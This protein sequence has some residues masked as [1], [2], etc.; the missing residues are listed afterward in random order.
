[1]G[2]YDFILNELFSEK[3][4]EYKSFLDYCDALQNTHLFIPYKNIV[5]ICDNPTEIKL[6]DRGQLHSFDGPAMTYADGYSLF[7]SN[8][9][10]V[11]K[12]WCQTKVKKVTKEMILKET[13]VDIRRETI[14]KVGMEAVSKILDSKVIDEKLG[15]KVITFD[16]GDGRVRPYL[17]MKNPSLKGVVHIEGLRPEIKTVEDAIKY[18]NSL[19]EFKMPLALS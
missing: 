11:T 6:N 16:I 13:N 15:Y 4:K 14:R 1:V 3:I 2:F 19:T 12:E 9:V 5:F 7:Y 18:R 10:K 17:Q 8:G